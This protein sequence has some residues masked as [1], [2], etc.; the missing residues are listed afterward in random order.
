M[1]TT[2]QLMY[3]YGVAWFGFDEASGSVVNKLDNNYIG[4]VSGGVRVE[5]WNGEG[6]AMN[7]DTV[8]NKKVAFNST[9]L[10]Y[11]GKTV[12]FKFKCTT[13]NNQY[14]L[15]MGNAKDYNTN[16][17]SFQ[18]SGGNGW[19]GTMHIGFRG[20]SATYEYPTLSTKNVC[21]GKWHESIFSLEGGTIGSKWRT[22]L[23]GELVS[24]GILKQ[25]ESSFSKNFEI[26]NRSYGN[27]GNYENL[28][29]D[30]LQIYN[31]ALSPS[32][33]EQRRLAVKTTN[34][35]NLVLSP[36]STRVKEIP[37]TA[38]YMMLAQGGVIKEIDSAVDRPPID[39]TKT[40][41]EY[42]IVTNKRTPLGEGR[43]FTIPIGSDFKTAM[44]EDN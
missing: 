27:S 24:E 44:I 3:Q 15:F 42:E 19:N 14:F 23:D 43:M 32:D 35:K 28:F 21:D 16:G 17:W 18:F 40:T 37:N 7:L 5:G 29:L 41:T 10:P 9:L 26:N 8:A 4:T 39:F 12:R 33:F 36:T 6:K 13:I 2:E 22:Y 30:D 11:G 25:N 20:S 1:A 34:N 31:K 38:E